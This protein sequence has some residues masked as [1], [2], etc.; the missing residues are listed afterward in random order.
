MAYSYGLFSY[1]LYGYG[2]YSY[3]LYSDGIGDLICYRARHTTPAHPITYTA[4]D[5][6]TQTPAQPRVAKD[7]GCC[8][9]PL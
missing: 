5:T 1:G 6:V 9:E 8:P 4:T 2:L 3:G 7:P